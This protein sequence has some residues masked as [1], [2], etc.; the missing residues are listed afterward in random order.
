MRR[1]LL[2]SCVVAG[3]TVGQV[4]HAQ[5]AP[6]LPFRAGQWG[7]EFSVANQTVGTIL[8]FDAP[9]RAWA[10]GGSLGGTWVWSNTTPPGD[11]SSA[12]LSLRISRRRYRA[13]TTGVAGYAALGAGVGLSR[14]WFPGSSRG[15]LS[16]G[17]LGQVGASWFVLPRLSVGADAALLVNLFRTRQREVV[18]GGPTT[19]RTTTGLS[20]FAG[21]FGLVGALYF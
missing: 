18:P 10:I 7:A 11:R 16:V 5:A 1:T 3:V 17:P 14:E 9:D 12:D 6:T 21:Q 15:S 20:V 8:R 2:V 13:L 4:V 19:I